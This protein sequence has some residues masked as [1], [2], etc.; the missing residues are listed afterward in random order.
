MGKYKVLALALKSY[1]SQLFGHLEN[2]GVFIFKQ[3]VIVCFQPEDLDKVK[4]IVKDSTSDVYEMEILSRGN[5]KLLQ[6][7]CSGND[8]KDEDCDK[9]YMETF[10]NKEE[11]SAVDEWDDGTEYKSKIYDE[12]ESMDVDER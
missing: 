10:L 12:K 2:F 9:W 6:L 11:K 5:G 1:A 7:N 3:S 8:C 4:A